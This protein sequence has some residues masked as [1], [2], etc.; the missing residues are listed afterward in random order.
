M[1]DAT[2]SRSRRRLPVPQPRQHGA[3]LRTPSVARWPG[4][5]AAQDFSFAP[6]RA[7][8]QCGCVPE[9]VCA[10]TR[11]S[12]QARRDEPTRLR[13][14]F[15]PRS[16]ESHKWYHWALNATGG[17]LLLLFWAFVLIAYFFGPAPARRWRLSTTT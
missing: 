14:G 3:A 5:F 6:L 7:R 9:S 16:S 8:T 17:V 13:R 4:S 15:R 12:S 10:R 1:H 11:R 2:V